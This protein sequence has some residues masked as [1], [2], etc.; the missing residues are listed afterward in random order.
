[1]AP[2]SSK[3]KIVKENLDYKLIVQ[4][5]KDQG[6]KNNEIHNILVSTY[7][8]D[9]SKA[10]KIINPPLTTGIDLGSSF[11]KFKS[12]LESII[13]EIMQ[14]YYDG[15]DNLSAFNIKK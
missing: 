9:N 11:D 7:G 14:E 6:K 5:L 2:T 13:H 4:D 12:Q 3:S 10:N 15:R 1:M 8:L